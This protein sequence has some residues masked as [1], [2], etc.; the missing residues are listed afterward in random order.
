MRYKIMKYQKYVKRISEAL[1]KYKADVD[2]LGGLYNAEHQKVQAK[3]TEMKGQWTD[4]Y[5]GRYILEHNP[6]ANFKARLQSAR[7][8]VEPGILDNLDRL[9]KSLDSYFNAPIKPD[10][11]NKIM[12]IKLSG[13]QLSDLEFKILQDSATSYMECRLL[14]QLAESRIRKNEIVELDENGTPRR[15]EAEMQDPYTKL[16]LPDIERTYKAF[17]DYKRSVRSLLYSYSGTK[18]EMS[19]LLDKE[20]PNYISVSMD[21][22]FRCH[23]EEEFT[24]VMEKANSILPESKVKRELTE[25]D[26]KLI[27]TL[28]DSK[29]PSLCKDRVRTLAE[30]DADIGEL[31][32]LDERYRDFLEE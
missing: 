18:A 30:A 11:A 7:T 3:A 19:H 12:A 9:Q 8:S 31:L 4:E 1:A 14:N 25:N 24:R 6:D 29:Y 26:K 13:L 15:K 32:A 20:L 16:K 22:Y 10:F 21:S 2:A 5:I 27:D 23:K 17:E 28:V